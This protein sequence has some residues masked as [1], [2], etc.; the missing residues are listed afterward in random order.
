[1][2]MWQQISTSLEYTDYLFEKD[3]SEALGFTSGDKPHQDIK[4]TGMLGLICFLNFIERI[5]NVYLKA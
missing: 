5:S 2:E 4:E 1:M 3:I